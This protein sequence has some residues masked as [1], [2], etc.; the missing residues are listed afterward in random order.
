MKI[1]MISDVHEQWDNLI[2]PTCD[3]LISA[4]DYSYRGN[5]LVVAAFHRWLDKQPAAHVISVQGNHELWVEKNFEEAKCLSPE[6]IHFIAEGLIDIEG[7]K[8]Y[9]S[10]VQPEFGGWAWNVA[11]GEK[12]KR[13]WDAIPEDVQILI[14]HG[15]ACGIL[16]QTA[17][18]QPRLGCE[19]LR[20]RIFELKKLKLHVFGHIHGSSGEMDLEGIKFINASICDEDYEPTNPVREFI[21]NAS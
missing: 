8:I 6:R 20:K 13:H 18:W 7:V 1:C 19:E 12:I 11:R 16:D 10:A 4:G 5:P 17:P 21:F 3:L 9:G 2:I 14:T 15:P